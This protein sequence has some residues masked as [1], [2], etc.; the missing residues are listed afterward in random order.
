MKCDRT[1]YNSI[2]N[3]LK[4]DNPIEE[5]EKEQ[6]SVIRSNSDRIDEDN[7]S[8]QIN[9][10]KS[11]EEVIDSVTAQDIQDFW[12]ETNI[13]LRKIKNLP[14]VKESDLKKVSVS[15]DSSILDQ[16]LVGT[17]KVAVFDLDET[18]VHRE[19]DDIKSCD[20]I[21]KV[22]IS[23]W[24]T[25]RLG[26]NIRPHLFE[27]LLKIKSEYILILFTSSMKIYADEAIKTFDPENKLF[28]YRLYRD[29]C[30]KLQC[31]NEETY[32]KDLRILK[33]IPLN[34]VVLID[35][36]I[37]SFA[38]Q[39]YNGIPILPFYN[40]KNDCELEI[41]SSYLIYLHQYDDI[42]LAN[43]RALKLDNIYNDVEESNSIYPKIPEEEFT[44]RFSCLFNYRRTSRLSTNKT[45]F[46]NISS[47][48]P[49]NLPVD[50]KIIESKIVLQNFEKES[51]K[52]KEA[53]CTKSA[54]SIKNFS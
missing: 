31:N 35:N 36:S 16:I 11:S 29:S 40:N 1:H 33:N 45:I 13:G 8:V 38:S 43:K 32:I 47:D 7:S 2:K 28:S 10:S 54:S 37:V 27:S 20:T 52:L 34:K 18:L 41:L 15:L 39:P 5:D 44:P 24:K 22:K 30:I 3:T 42:R 51:V 4:S 48:H 50:S 14:Q 19:A 6:M 49:N 25:T 23:K 12:E 26:L 21:I 9:D 53:L 17:K 46:F